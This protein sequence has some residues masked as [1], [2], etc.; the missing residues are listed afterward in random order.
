MNRQERGNGEIS[1]LNLLQVGKT[2]TVDLRWNVKW[3]YRSE[4]TLIGISHMSLP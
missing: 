4:R 3:N 2:H 1:E